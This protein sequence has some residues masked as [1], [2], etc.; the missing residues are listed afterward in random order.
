MGDAENDQAQ[1][2][3]SGSLGHRVAPSVIS[4]NLL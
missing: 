2:Y 1:T 4:G 3:Q